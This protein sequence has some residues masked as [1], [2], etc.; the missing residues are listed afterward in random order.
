MEQ[1]E[2]LIPQDMFLKGLFLKL[3]LWG[4]HWLVTS[5]RFQMHSPTVPRRCVTLCAHCPVSSPS[6]TLY[7]RGS[8]NCAWLTSA[9]PVQC[10]LGGAPDEAAGRHSPGGRSTTVMAGATRTR[11]RDAQG[12]WGP[13]CRAHVGPGTQARSAGRE[14]SGKRGR[15]IQKDRALAFQHLG[16]FICSSERACSWSEKAGISVMLVLLTRRLL[17]PWLLSLSPR[18]YSWKCWQLPVCV[19]CVLAPVPR[20][21]CSDLLKWPS[22]SERWI[23]ENKYPPCLHLPAGHFWG[24]APTVEVAHNSTVVVSCASWMTFQRLPAPT[25]VS[26]PASEEKQSSPELGEVLIYLLCCRCV[27]FSKLFL[28]E[29]QAIHVNC[30]KR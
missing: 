5:H 6:S 16:K 25:P 26:P 22:S 18:W 30:T 17:P 1:W 29:S 2:L 13:L 28:L 27:S 21:A 24:T 7:R 4:W 23:S 20:G 19:P 8:E 9:S 15:Q 11:D 14:S 12:L 3:N 10:Q